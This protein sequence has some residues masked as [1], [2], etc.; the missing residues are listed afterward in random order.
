MFDVK[1]APLMSAMLFLGSNWRGEEEE[2]GGGERRG[3]EVL[4]HPCFNGRYPPL[5]HLLLFL[6]LFVL[7]LLLFVNFVLLRPDR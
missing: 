4:R 3:E 1:G 2:E 5:L 6:L 7:F